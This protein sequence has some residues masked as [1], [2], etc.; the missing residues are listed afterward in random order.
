MTVRLA[1]RITAAIVLTGFVASGVIFVAARPVEALVDDPLLNKKYIME[2]ERYG[3]RANVA[4]AEFMQW[5]RSLWEGQTLAYTIAVLA[6]VAA[7]VFRWLATLPPV[8]VPAG[9]SEAERVD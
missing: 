3:G 7:F 2:L 1:N 8:D 6:L 5:F 9:N 4:S